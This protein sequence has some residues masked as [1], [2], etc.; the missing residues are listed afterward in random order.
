MDCGSII[1]LHFALKLVLVEFAALG[2]VFPTF[3]LTFCRSLAPV[4]LIAFT[5]LSYLEVFLLVLPFLS[6]SRHPSFQP[7]SMYLIFCVLEEK[8]L[9]GSMK[10]AGRNYMSDPVC[11]CLDLTMLLNRKLKICKSALM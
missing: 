11:S 9:V 10:T 5:Q 6:A 7:Q 2:A 3:N 8:E 1:Y 4:F